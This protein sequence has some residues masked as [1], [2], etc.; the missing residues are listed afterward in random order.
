MNLLTRSA[1]TGAQRLCRGYGVHH[2]TE[3][4]SPAVTHPNPRQ[5]RGAPSALLPH[6]SKFDPASTTFK[7]RL[8]P[9]PHSPKTPPTPSPPRHFHTAPRPAPKSSPAPPP[10]TPDP[11]PTSPQSPRTPPATPR[12]NPPPPSTGTSRA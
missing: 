1:Q 6:G 11:S 4:V 3:N 2:P 5:S 8:P 12:R 7:V 9:P 10:D